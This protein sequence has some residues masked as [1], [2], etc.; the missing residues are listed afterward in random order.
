[1]KIVAFIVGF[2]AFIATIVTAIY[3]TLYVYQLAIIQLQQVIHCAVNTL[4][5]WLI[6]ALLLG[7][8]ALVKPFEIRKSATK[9]LDSPRPLRRAR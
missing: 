2:I 1:M 4:D 5:L 7:M 8:N 3:L 9:T 6:F